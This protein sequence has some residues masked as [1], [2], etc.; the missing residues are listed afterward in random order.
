MEMNALFLQLLTGLQ[1]GAIYALIALGLTLIFGTLGF[2][3]F[4]H[5]ALYVIA[6]YAA[7]TIGAHTSFVLAILLVPIL[8]FLIGV[9]FERGLIRHFYTR[10]H[11]D[12][13][14]I[15]FGIA[16]VVEEMMKWWFG[17]NNIPFNLPEW[18]SGLMVFYSDWSAV[19]PAPIFQNAPALWV[20]FLDGFVTYQFWRI[21]LIVVSLITV[22]ALFAL[23]QFTRFGLVVR[24]GMRDPEM[25]RFLGINISQKFAIVVGMGAAI[26]GIAGVFGGP[27]TQVTPGVGMALLVPSF[28]VVVIGGMGSLTGALVAAILIG[29]ALSFSAEIADLQQIV[30]YLIAVV[31]LLVR[32]RGLFGKKGVFE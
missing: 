25:L 18:G 14:L 21:V 32:P 11:T 5:G 22:G 27:V 10:P 26:A 4:A 30:I 28:L 12:Q 23:L 1:L 2:V 16:I 9:V 20:P 24:A 19:P 31:V 17:A 29:M 8:L 15:T 6:I 7:V 13:I 3:N